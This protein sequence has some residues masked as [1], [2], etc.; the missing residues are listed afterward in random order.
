MPSGLRIDRQG[1]DEEDRQ[2]AEEGGCER[3]RTVPLEL[4]SPSPRKPHETK[5]HE[6]CAGPDQ[7]QQNL[8]SIHDT[9]ALPFLTSLHQ[10]IRKSHTPGQQEDQPAEQSFSRIS[11]GFGFI[12]SILEGRL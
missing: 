9:G 7:C 4:R 10:K 2:G 12:D 1:G 8:I 3:E 6:R 11:F 5:C